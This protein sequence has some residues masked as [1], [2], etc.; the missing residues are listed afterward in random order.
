MRRRILN[1]DVSSLIICSMCGSRLRSL[2]DTGTSV[3]DDEDEYL[4]AP[5]GY[6]D[7][8]IMYIDERN[9]ILDYL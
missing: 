2:E 6:E 3:E 5:M 4:D 7:D 9:D 1:E 8:M